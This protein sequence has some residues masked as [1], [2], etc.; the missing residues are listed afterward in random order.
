[1]EILL[2]LLSDDRLARIREVISN[3]TRTVVSV[4][5]GAANM[6]NVN[7]VMRTAEGLGFFEFHLVSAEETLKHARRSSQGAE[8]WMDIRVWG[9]SH[10]CIPSL[11]DAG[12]KIVT[13]SPDLKAEPLEVIDFTQPT[14]L[15]FGNE[16]EGV[17]EATVKMSD[18]V[19]RVE[20]AGFVESYNISVAAALCLYHAYRDRVARLGYQGDLGQDEADSLMAVYALRAVQH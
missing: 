19:A 10:D 16:L 4:V 9:S 11:K 8:K 13:T 18:V 12:Y 20:L 6:G 1:M 2:P 14:A 3:R 5:E 15:V 7:A 17:S